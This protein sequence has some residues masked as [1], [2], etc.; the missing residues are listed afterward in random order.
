M[1]PLRDDRTP[2]PDD[3]LTAEVEYDVEQR[4]AWWG[5]SRHY[6]MLRVNILS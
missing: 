5:A 1:P 6:L 4:D 2:L 3:I